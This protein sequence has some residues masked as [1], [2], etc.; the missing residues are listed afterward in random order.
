MGAKLLGFREVALSDGNRRGKVSD[1]FVNSSG[2]LVGMVSA[3]VL[4]I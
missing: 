4:A 1:A 3:A 2:E